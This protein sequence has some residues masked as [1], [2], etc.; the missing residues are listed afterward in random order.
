M[1]RKSRWAVYQC[2]N[3]CI[4]VRLQNV[5]VTLTLREFAQLVELL[6]DAYVRLGVR[7]AVETVRHH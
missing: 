4:H 1:S 5:T 6:G 7:A 2:T 3:G